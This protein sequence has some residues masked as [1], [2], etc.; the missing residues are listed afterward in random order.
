MG[1]A[2]EPRPLPRLRAD[3]P[4]QVWGWD[5]SYLPTNVKSIWLCLYLVM[6][7]W[8]MKVVALDV[9]DRENP[10]L[11]ADLVSKAGLRERITRRRKQPL[12]LHAD[13]GNALAAGFSKSC[14]QPPWRCA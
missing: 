5:I 8:S 6:D 10:K 14:E 1:L 3:G 11:A 4:N 12:I 2:M 7:G 13:N 9:E